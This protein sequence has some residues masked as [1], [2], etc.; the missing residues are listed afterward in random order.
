MHLYSFLFPKLILT[1]LYNTNNNTN[2]QK[3]VFYVKGLPRTYLAISIVLI[4]LCLLVFFTFGLLP[5][6]LFRSEF[7]VAI[8]MS[9]YFI[10]QA[11]DAPTPNDWSSRFIR[12][13]NSFPGYDASLLVKA[14]QENG[15]EEIWCILL[16][17]EH[18]L[19]KYKSRKA[20]T[21][22]PFDA[23]GSNSDEDIEDKF[24]VLKLKEVTYKLETIREAKYVERL[25]HAGVQRVIYVMVSWRLL[26]YEMRNKPLDALQNF[27]AD[28]HESLTVL[29]LGR[30]QLQEFYSPSLVPFASYLR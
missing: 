3:L 1:V 6:M 30:E 12:C 24:P 16:E 11:I 17:F 2:K 21:A 10:V 25:L 20:A 8:G 26:P 7:W 15:K 13:T 27:E 23:A 19:K 14:N 5:S 22:R 4:V 9:I 28:Q 29:L 18:S